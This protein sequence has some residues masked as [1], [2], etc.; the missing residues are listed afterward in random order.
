MSLKI[1]FLLI[2]FSCFLFSGFVGVVFTKRPAL[3]RYLNILL[4]IKYIE[5][6]KIRSN[7][8]GKQKAD[9]IEGFREAIAE[10]DKVDSEIE[11]AKHKKL[12]KHNEMQT[13]LRGLQKEKAYHEDSYTKAKNT[14]EKTE[15]DL[16]YAAQQKCPTCEQELHDDKHEQ[17]ITK[18]KTTLRSYSGKTRVIHKILTESNYSKIKDGY[19]IVCIPFKSFPNYKKLNW[20]TLKEIRF[21]LLENSN[22]KIGDFKIIEFRGNPEKPFQ[23][24]GM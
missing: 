4:Y 20:T 16:E 11:I 23:W 10:L 24:R 7:A 5:S 22:F 18:L 6:L 8:W 1:V 21:K 17:L 2:F 14:V 13:A 12:Q 3:G 15:G 9:D 19:Y